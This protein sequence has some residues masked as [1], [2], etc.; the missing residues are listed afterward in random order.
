MNQQGEVGLNSQTVNLDPKCLFYQSKNSNLIQ[1][2]N[3][4]LNITGFEEQKSNSSYCN[5]FDSEAKANSQQKKMRKISNENILL[6]PSLN[7]IAQLSEMSIAS[8]LQQQSG[9]LKT[10]KKKNI[11]D[12]LLSKR[13][14]LEEQNADI[15]RGSSTNYIQ[16]FIIQRVFKKVKVGAIF[17]EMQKSQKLIKSNMYVINNYMKQRR[18]SFQL[19]HKI[20]HYLEYYW[21]ESEFSSTKQEQRII[22][23]LSDNLK[24]N[25]LIEANK[26]FILESPILKKHFS[27]QSLLQTISIAQEQKFTP[28]EVIYLKGDMDFAIYFIERGSVEVQIE[29]LNNNYQKQNKNFQL[30]LKQGQFFGEGSFFTGNPRRQTF[31]SLEFTTVLKIEREEFIKIIEESKEDYETFCYIKD[32][33]IL[34]SSTQFSRKCGL[35]QS[36]DEEIHNEINCP[37]FHFVPNIE[38]LQN[39]FIYQAINTDRV[40]KSRR[41][42]KFKTN[43]VQLREIQDDQIKFVDQ[44]MSFIKEKYEYNDHNNQ[45]SKA[46]TNLT[47]SSQDFDSEE[48]EDDILSIRNH[49]KNQSEKAINSHVFINSIGQRQSQSKQDMIQ[50]H[51]V[52]QNNEGAHQRSSLIIEKS[53][54]DNRNQSS[55]KRASFQLNIL[56]AKKNITQK[57]G[58]DRLQYKLYEIKDQSSPESNQQQRSSLNQQLETNKQDILEQNYIQG[59]ITTNNNNNESQRKTSRPFKKDTI[60]L[61][62]NSMIEMSNQASD[63]FNISPQKYSSKQSILNNNNFSAL[64]QTVYQNQYETFQEIENFDKMQIFEIYFPSNNYDYVI[65]YLQKRLKLLSKNKKD[66]RF[67]EKKNKSNFEVSAF[68]KSQRSLRKS[69]SASKLNSIQNSPEKLNN[70]NPYKI[71][72]NG[73]EK[74]DNS[75]LVENDSYQNSKLLSPTYKSLKDKNSF[76]ENDNDEK[77]SQ[78]L[79]LTRVNIQSW[80]T[81]AVNSRKS[82][83]NRKSIS[84]TI[85]IKHSLS[86]QLQNMSQQAVQ[87]NQ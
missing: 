27:M 23:Q 58:N 78:I 15:R 20:R 14:I 6:T 54:A 33:I 32:Q 34:N 43:L 64:N 44:N 77:S 4:A 31:R 29:G 63:D 68:S 3:R 72:L 18:I 39:K 73:Q 2:T 85:K 38:R 13:Q 28:Q 57:E 60:I 19:Q 40:K 87:Q 55:I 5:F 45:T 37:F 51:P 11:R 10:K 1:I 76:E 66:N 9:S 69:I 41:S 67:L 84:H 82:F 42:Y 22:N 52:R 25:L 48:D 79:G 62:R 71:L 70:G 8:N 75:K 21:N 46:K 17:Q 49:A 61:N 47:F 83:F 16:T 59:N 86:Q 50:I 36:D 65:P 80:Q 56:S 81:Q 24:E 7:N 30:I 53:S 26:V 35:C 12:I 74:Q